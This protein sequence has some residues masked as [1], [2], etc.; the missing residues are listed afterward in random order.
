MTPPDDFDYDDVPDDIM[1]QADQ[2]F[3]NEQAKADEL[4]NPQ[5]WEFD[6]NDPKL[7]EAD[8]TFQPVSFDDAEEAQEQALAAI[9]DEETLNKA[10]EE[11]FNRDISFSTPIVSGLLFRSSIAAIYGASHTGKTLLA[12]G[13][14]SCI[15]RGVP[16]G[17]LGVRR[18]PV[19]YL[20][21]ESSTDFNKRYRAELETAGVE[22]M[23]SFKVRHGAFDVRDPIE[24]ETL[25]RVLPKVFGD[26]HYPPL[27]I[28]DT[29]AQHLSGVPGE[30]IDENSAKDI[31]KYIYGLRDISE[32]TGGTILLI[33][34]SGKDATKGIR[35]SSALKGALDTEIMVESDTD[36]ENKLVKVTVTKQRFCSAID[37]ACYKIKSIILKSIKGGVEQQIDDEDVMI[38]PE[39]KEGQF[40]RTIS[41]SNQSAVIDPE[42]L[43]VSDGD[44]D[45]PEYQPKKTSTNYVKGEASDRARIAVEIAQNYFKGKSDMMS[46]VNAWE[47]EGHPKGGCRNALKEAEK[48]GLVTI[49]GDMVTCSV[50]PSSM[51]V[52]GSPKDYEQSKDEEF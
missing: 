11:W 26:K 5:A 45:E 50:L 27:F 33:A 13:L 46:I 23:P 4:E 28:F 6:P 35:G 1:E 48:Y 41:P 3:R 30:A 32:R 40:T 10:V 29:F 24:R 2:H 19:M 31:G 15:S 8:D 21:A 39:R 20:N 14:S 22:E 52:I 16:F 38:M 49:I 12:S 7:F 9:V 51:G 44:D 47:A 42:P 37:P 25:I 17:D 36:G 43:P 18:G 34:H